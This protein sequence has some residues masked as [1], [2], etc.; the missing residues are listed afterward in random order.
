MT[1]VPRDSAT[2]SRDTPRTATSSGLRSELSEKTRSQVGQYYNPIPMKLEKFTLGVGDRFGHEGCAQLKALQQAAREGVNI[3]PVWNKSYR[4]H[5]IIGT[6]PA[7]TRK[8][9]DEAVRAC[10]WSA[11][12]YVDADHIGLKT[13]DLFTASSDYYTLDVADFI[14]APASPQ[15]VDAFVKSMKDF[16]GRLEI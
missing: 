6:T 2:K 13:V 4:E 9:A 5:S 3:S 11:P 14:G 8:A 10:G 15:S 1:L 12:Y 7:D 16:S